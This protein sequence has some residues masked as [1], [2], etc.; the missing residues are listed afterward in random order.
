[1]RRESVNRFFS[2]RGGDLVILAFSLLLAFFMWSMYRMTGKYSAVFDYKIYIQ[3]N[4]A[5][6]SRSAVSSNSLVIRGR[7]SG[8]YIFQQRSNVDSGKNEIAVSVDSKDLTSYNKGE[9]IFYLLATDLE[10]QVQEFLGSD[11]KLEG[12]SSDTLFFHFPKQANI[13]VPVVVKENITF[14]PQYAAPMGMSIK[15]DS[16]VIYGDKSIISKITYVETQNVRHSKVDEPVQGVV[17][18]R[19]VKGVSY[20]SQEAYYS[21]NVVRYF[22]NVITLKIE[23]EN[24]PSGA[25]VLFIPQQVDVRYRMPFNIKKEF[26]ESDFRVMVNYDSIGRSN[27]VRPMIIE[28]PEGLFDVRIEPLFVECLVN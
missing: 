22:E 9:D 1:M 12:I 13:K 28:K 27:I 20:S 25:N 15:P 11:F 2:R 5:G 7:A 8:F 17:K 10:E 16:V 24:F 23:E 21:L 14:A 4:I 18:L 19:P 3:S 6:H 26:Q